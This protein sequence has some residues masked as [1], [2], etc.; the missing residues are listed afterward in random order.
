[1]SVYADASLL[2]AAFTHEV[3]SEP[4]RSW[5]AQLA[6][7]ELIF[8]GWCETEIA[9]ALA[10]KV[11]RGELTVAQEKVIAQ[12]VLRLLGVSG[13]AVSI[14][15]VHF[16]DA[17]DLIRQSPKPLRGGDALH[18][19]IARSNRATLWTLDKGMARAGEALDL[20]AR[21]LA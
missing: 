20:G 13:T 21:L 16:R 3:E 5:L 1:M 11:R 8:S 10:M 6:P 7:G 4:A 19:S 14:V 18:L 2:V 12:D 17:A 9:S 15:E